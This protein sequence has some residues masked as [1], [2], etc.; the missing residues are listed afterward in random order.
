[1]FH[2]SIEKSFALFAVTLY[3]A[4]KRKCQ[5][6]QKRYGRRCTI[7]Q[8]LTCTLLLTII[9]ICLS[10]RDSS[11]TDNDLFVHKEVTVFKY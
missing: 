4:E 5:N 11:W 3:I 1:M 7:F 8:H 9:D 2:P 6:Q 10:N